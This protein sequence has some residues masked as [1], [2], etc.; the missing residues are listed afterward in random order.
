MPRFLTD[1][2]GQRTTQDINWKTYFQ[3]SPLSFQT[4]DDKLSLV[5][6]TLLRQHI[7][8][9]EI[10]LERDFHRDLK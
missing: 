6:L 4:K 3:L 1:S 8:L 2:I 7:F 9:S 10:H 5:M